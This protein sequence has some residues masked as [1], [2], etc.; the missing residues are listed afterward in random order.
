MIQV[1]QCKIYQLQGVGFKLD[2]GQMKQIMLTRLD[3]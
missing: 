1:Q 2:F 3:D